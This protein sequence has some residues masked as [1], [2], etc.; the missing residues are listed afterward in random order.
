MD[1]AGEV[2]VRNLDVLHIRVKQLQEIVGDRGF[3][4]VLHTNAELVGIG[5][6]EIEREVVVVPH[7]LDKLEKI[8]HIHAE[9]MLRGAVIRLKTVR[10]KAEIDEHGVCLIHRH[11]LNALRIKLQIRLRQNLLQSL[12]KSANS[13]GLYRFDLKKIAVGIHVRASKRQSI[14]FS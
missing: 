14:L 10:V 11:D 9:H 6:G 8:D 4:R 3:L 7:R 12:H 2:E 5:R 1:N 13:T